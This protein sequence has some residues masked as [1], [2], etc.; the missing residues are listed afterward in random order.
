M[1]TVFTLFDEALSRSIRGM[2]CRSEA[3]DRFVDDH[4]PFPPGEEVVITTMGFV[5]PQVRG[6][7]TAFTSRKTIRA[8]TPIELEESA[9]TDC[10]VLGELTNML[11]GRVKN[12]LLGSGLALL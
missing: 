5:C 10:D 7:L 3:A 1:E 6:G 11:L 2:F 9:T 8:L 4:V 12:Q